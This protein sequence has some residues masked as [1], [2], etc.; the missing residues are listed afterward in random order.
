MADI[1]NIKNFFVTWYDESN[2]YVTT[3]DIT[4]E[5]LGISFTDTGSGQVNECVLKLSG[6]FGNFITDEGTPIVIDQY[7]RFQVQCE[8]LVGNTY[9]RFF[10]FNPLIVPSQTKTEGTLLELNLI[11]TEYHT[12]RISFAGRFWFSDAFRVARE[13]GVS[14]NENTNTRQPVLSGHSIG[15]IQATGTG[16]GFPRFTVNHYEYGLVEDSGYNR[17]NQMLDK[18]GGSVAAGGVLDY[19]ECGFETSAI[20]AIE[21]A[22]FSSGGRSID[23]DDD[24]ALPT[25]TQ[26]LEVNIGSTD[27]GIAAATASQVAVWGSQTHGSLPT[28]HSKYASGVDQFIFRPQWDENISY[29]Q[30]SV[31]K[32]LDNKHYRANTD[33]TGIP[34]FTNPA[35]SGDWDQ[36]DM[37]DEFGDTIQ[38]SEWTDDRVKEWAKTKK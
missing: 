34:P 19:F 36:I 22:L 23:L 14:F 38:Y 17:W 11:G 27:V 28:G 33:I 32:Y 16:N 7:D 10:E 4:T 31:V 6:A 24:A 3:S 12:Q 25:L 18:L 37:S 30:F 8:D 15:Y 26:S 5:V 35:A 29:L 21:I 1:G 9:N 13:I 2:N 20:N